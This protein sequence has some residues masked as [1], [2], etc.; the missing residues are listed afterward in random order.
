MSELFLNRNPKNARRVFIQ[1]PN[2]KIAE[3]KDWVALGAVT[4]VKDQQVRTRCSC[5]V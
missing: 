2:V 1:Q 4:P 3:S 5:G